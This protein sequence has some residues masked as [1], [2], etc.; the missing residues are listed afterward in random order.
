MVHNYRVS[1]VCPVLEVRPLSGAI[2]AEIRGIDLTRELPDET[3]ADS[4]AHGSR[5]R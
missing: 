5:T 2:G 4:G 1:V 3:I